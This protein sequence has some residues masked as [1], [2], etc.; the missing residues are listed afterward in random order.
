MI[1]WWIFWIF[2]CFFGWF[3]APILNTKLRLSFNIF[4][5]DPTADVYLFV[6]SKCTQESK[7][8]RGDNMNS[9]IFVVFAEM[10]NII[11]FFE[12]KSHVSRFKLLRVDTKYQLINSQIRDLI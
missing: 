3:N 6:R 9:K 8:L 5:L 12:K 4:I 7:N 11:I 1:S 2:K 10:S